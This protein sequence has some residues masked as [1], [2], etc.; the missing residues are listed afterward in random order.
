LSAGEFSNTCLQNIIIDECIEKF[1][2]I[3]IEFV[4]VNIIYAR[5]KK[6]MFLLDDIHRNYI[7]IHKFNTNDIV[8]IK[9]VAGSGKTTTLLNLSKI[10]N[11][12]IVLQI[13]T[14]VIINA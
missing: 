6:S 4:N 12:K 11:N 7:N 14:R 5:C 13:N 8:A 3:N 10:H 1:N 2:S 9:S